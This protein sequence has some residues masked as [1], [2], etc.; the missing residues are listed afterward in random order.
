MEEHEGDEE[1][2]LLFV[3][4][5]LSIPLRCL[6]EEDRA[7]SLEE[8]N[9]SSEE[10]VRELTVTVQ[11]LNRDNRALQVVSF[12]YVCASYCVCVCVCVCACMCVL[13]CVLCICVCV[14]VCVAVC[15]CVVCIPHVQSPTKHHS[16]TAIC[17]LTYTRYN[18]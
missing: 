18:V 3:V 7:T 16:N 8:K 12:V 2:E 10:R 11:E 9:K 13:V 4:P 1:G 14:F 17:V 5:P 15:V 6:E